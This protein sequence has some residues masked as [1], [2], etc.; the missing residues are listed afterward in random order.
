KWRLSRSCRSRERSSHRRRWLRARWIASDAASIS[1][2]PGSSPRPAATAWRRS[3]ASHRWTSASAEAMAAASSPPPPSAAP[4]PAPPQA[5]SQPLQPPLMVGA[6]LPRG[7]QRGEGARPTIEDL[8]R[9]RL[10]MLRQEALA[11]LE[12]PRRLLFLLL[13]RQSRVDRSRSPRRQL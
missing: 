5:I 4:P 3:S 12:P 2:T 9:L 7:P 13:G 1:T 11:L 8:D 6:L 10:P